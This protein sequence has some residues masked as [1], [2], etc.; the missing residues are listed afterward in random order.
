MRIRPAVTGRYSDEDPD[1]IADLGMEIHGVSSAAK[2]L[3]SWTAQQAVQECR[4]ACGGHG[5]LAAAG[6]GRI[7]F[8]KF[9]IFLCLCPKV[10]VSL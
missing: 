3:G 4:E 10:L 7:R 2:P 8:L 9:K 5:Y 6:L 1:T